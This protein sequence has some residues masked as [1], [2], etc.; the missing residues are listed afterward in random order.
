MT[1]CVF[2]EGKIPDEFNVGL[3]KRKPIYI[4]FPQAVPQVVLIDP[5]YCIE[6]KTGKCKKTCVEAC[7]DARRSTSSRKRSRRDQ[8]RHHHPGHRLQDLRRRSHSVNTATALY[9]TSTPRSKWSAWS[10]LPVRPGVRS[11]LRDGK[12]PKIGR[13]HPLRRLARHEDQPLVLRVC[14]MYSLKLAHLVQG[15]YRCRS[16]QLLHRHAT[17][18]QGLRGVLRQVAR[19][20]SALRSWAVAEVTDWA[21]RPAEEGKLVIRVE[22]TL[23]GFVRR[24]PVDM[25]VL[26]VGH[27]A[28]GRR[29]GRA[30]AVQHE[31]LHRRLVPGAASEACA[32]EHLHRR[33]LHR[34]RVPG[35]EGH[36]RQHC[37]GRRRG[38]RGDG[39]DRQ[40]YIEQ[41]PN[42]AYIVEE[43]CSGCKSCIPLCPYTAISFVEDKKKARSTRPCAKAAAPAC[44]LPVGFDPAEPLRRRG[45]LQRNRRSAGLC[46]NPRLTHIHEMPQ[47]DSN[48]ASSRSSATGAPTRRPTSRAFRG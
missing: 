35:A 20:R 46:C 22:D 36:P 9:R 13:H 41:E 25:V 31:L 33:H 30:A 48:R 5:R 8:S 44:G 10:M 39:A 19:R 27:G 38:G 32:G 29:P 16:V 12:R 45:D 42:T 37:P 4:P 26:A 24:I 14:C 40:G 6:F 3:S 7:G 18:G 11:I 1:A 28:A 17:P 43:E 21:H 2:K 15:A 34:R 47:T 23:A